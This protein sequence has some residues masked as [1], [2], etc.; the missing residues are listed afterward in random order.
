[1]L[2]L[3]QATVERSLLLDCLAAWMS[4][5]STRSGCTD[6]LVADAQ[7]FGRLSAVLTLND[8][9]VAD[10]QSMQTQQGLNNC[11]DHIVPSV[12]LL[13]SVLARH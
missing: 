10:A 13:D 9:L 7:S 1:M 5:V 11:N 3:T 12:I 6:R 8:D 2:S 4:F